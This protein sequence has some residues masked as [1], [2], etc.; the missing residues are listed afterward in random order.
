[1]NDHAKPSLELR[2]YLRSLS[3]EQVQTMAAAIASANSKPELQATLR[4]S[5]AAIPMVDDI[6]TSINANKA[7]GDT[8]QHNVMQGQ[9]I[10][11]MAIF[12]FAEDQG[13]IW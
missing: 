3:L 1:M 4:E 9:L 6:Q 13:Y 7:A 10:L 11:M 2:D 12:R 8:Q 5:A